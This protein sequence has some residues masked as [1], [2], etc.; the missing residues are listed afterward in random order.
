MNIVIIG[1]G[2]A[3]IFAA[4]ELAKKHK[5]TLIDQN[6]YIGG[7]GLHSDGK[8]N[9]SYKDVGAD[10]LTKFTSE[11]EL[12]QIL[13]NL[14][15][16]FAIHGVN[17]AYPSN[18]VIEELQE[19]CRLANLTYTPVRQAH[20]GSDKLRNIMSNIHVLIS[21]RMKIKLNTTITSVFTDCI[22]TDKNEIIPY[23]K[24]IIAVGRTGSLSFFNF[25]NTLNIN[26]EYTPIDIGVRVEVPSKST[27]YI[28][29]EL[30]LWDPKIHTYSAKD[31]KVRTF[32]TCPYGYIRLESYGKYNNID[33]VGVNG[34]SDNGKRGDNSNFAIM[35]TVHLTKPFEDTTALGQQIVQLTNLLGG[36]KP[37]VQILDDFIRGRRST[38][39]RLN[40]LNMRP[41]LLPQLR[42]PGDINFAYSR[43]IVENIIDGIMDLSYIIDM[44]PTNTVLYAPEVK[45]YANKI[46]FEEGFRTTRPNIFIAGD[47]SGYSRGIIGA[48]ITGIITARQILDEGTC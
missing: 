11:D 23:D 46:Q 13:E 47:C 39:S 3:G 25:Y 20:I 44:D 40:H 26:Y 10:D 15:I 2:P 27:D 42:T 45:F 14:K 4:I 37:L 21:N 34:Y 5:V 33:M 22:I 16:T 41:T 28:V 30:G 17:S 38:I 43:K 35:N 36:G 12:K 9:F 18:S 6:S 1:A 48:A 29:E 24:L 32:C 19:K 7:S 8:L 31:E